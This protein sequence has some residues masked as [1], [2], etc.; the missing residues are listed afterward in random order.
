MD[1]GQALAMMRYANQLQD[2][3]NRYNARPNLD[4]ADIASAP[5]ENYEP[6]AMQPSMM[7]SVPEQFAPPVPSIGRAISI[8]PEYIPDAAVARYA[9]AQEPDLSV[10]GYEPQVP[11]E[12]RGMPA[13]MADQTFK[14][15]YGQPQPMPASRTYPLP[16]ALDTSTGTGIAGAM[17]S[18]DRQYSRLAVTPL[19]IPGMPVP[20][21]DVPMTD[22]VEPGRNIALAEGGEQDML[23]PVAPSVQKKP[24][25]VEVPAKPKT[26][27]DN[28]QTPYV[29][30]VKPQPQPEVEQKPVFK[31]GEPFGVTLEIGGTPVQA[32][33]TKF[34]PTYEGDINPPETAIVEIPGRG[35]VRINPENPNYEKIKQTF[36]SLLPAPKPADIYTSQVKV[37]GNWVPARLDE[38]SQRVVYNDPDLGEVEYKDI[39]EI[40]PNEDYLGPVDKYG[41]Y[42]NEPLLNLQQQRGNFMKPK[43]QQLMSTATGLQGNLTRDEII[44]NL[45]PS[46]GAATPE[47]PW[48]EL[49]WNLTIPAGSQGAGQ[50]VSIE[51]AA[52]MG[53]VSQNLANQINAE[54]NNMK[55]MAKSTAEGIKAMQ[56]AK[57]QGIDERDLEK[58]NNQIDDLENELL[59]AQ[60][61]NR[62]AKEI[63]DLDKRLADRRKARLDIMSRSVSGVNIGGGSTAYEAPADV[64]AYSFPDPNSLEGQLMALSGVNARN[65]QEKS[66]NVLTP[67]Q[68]AMMA[69]HNALNNAPPSPVVMAPEY[70][71]AISTLVRRLQ[72][73][74]DDSIKVYGSNANKVLRSP[75]VLTY[76]D[77]ANYAT[78]NLAAGEGIGKQIDDFIAAYEEYKTQKNS[79]NEAAA[80]AAKQKLS[81][82]AKPLSHIIS[83][84][85][86]GTYRPEG[87]EIR[88]LVALRNVDQMLQAPAQID[89]S[90]AGRTTASPSMEKKEAPKLAVSNPPGGSKTKTAQ[91]APIFPIY[92]VSPGKNILIDSGTNLFGEIVNGG[93]EAFDAHATSLMPGQSVFYNQNTL[94]RVM[95]N[96]DGTLNTEQAQAI[97]NTIQKFNQEA[98]KP[99][100]GADIRKRLVDIF[101]D[102]MR[103]VGLH[104]SL[105]AV[106]VF[107]RLEKIRSDVQAA[108]DAG[109][110]DAE[111][112][113]IA[114]A[115]IQSF[116]SQLFDRTQQLM[117]NQKKIAQTIRA[118]YS[119]PQGNIIDS[120]RGSINVTGETKPE[121]LAKNTFYLFDQMYFS[122]VELAQLFAAA[123]LGAT[124]YTNP[125]NNKS[126]TWLI[127]PADQNVAKVAHSVIT[128]PTSAKIGANAQSPMQYQDAKDLE[129]KVQKIGAPVDP[130]H[131]AVLIQIDGIA[132]D[133][134]GAT[135]TTKGLYELIGGQADD[136]VNEASKE[137][138]KLQTNTVDGGKNAA[139]GNSRREPSRNS[140]LDFDSRS[141]EVIRQN[142]VSNII[143]GNVF[144]ADRIR[145]PYG[146]VLFSTNQ[147][148]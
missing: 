92:E 102:A 114:Q 19:P 138:G 55:S 105:D 90:V 69:L 117:F 145:A 7:Q 41:Q 27:F 74:Q 132:G 47:N 28:I 8:P 16:M 106:G 129:S 146:T 37:D 3:S 2:Y 83:I 78:K 42:Q 100:E 147:A 50:V 123:G 137:Y 31:P 12:Q 68:V 13:F 144:G 75:A 130:A 62:P 93:K 113:R 116:M 103:A 119:D 101:Y 94:G 96:D 40:V 53:L 43:L 64:Y 59:Q 10:A 11:I 88:K 1:L 21:T 52:K 4:W 124:S 66:Y 17:P 133:V 23:R 140:A 128:I 51:D 20:T 122:A 108:K 89:M 104:K 58:V 26:Q 63:Q 121:W 120:Y 38:K 99:V 77:G 86:L 67:N 32:T 79:G 22:I 29:P 135:A 139:V 125:T 33:V 24:F 115:G 95:L 6:Y 61:D 80:E 143:L 9:P 127:N 56:G 87:D 136:I 34:Q 82:A 15:L 112:N 126:V 14:E 5:A 142:A 107:D 46:Y 109:K 25:Q 39:M 72:R 97:D 91:H 85:G 60:A 54:F 84:P 36:T 81:E 110:P 71:D 35:T 148:K 141:K 18:L 73:I 65:L 131:H 30:Q 76:P 44:S 48:G 70:K 49:S 98:I 45:R 111:I 134:L 118:S 57:P